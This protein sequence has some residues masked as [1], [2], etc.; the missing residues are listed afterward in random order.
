MNLTQFRLAG[1]EPKGI[2][3]YIHLHVF[4]T[5]GHQA[6]WKRLRINQDQCVEQMKQSHETALQAIS[7]SE[8]SSRPENASH[9]REQLVLQFSRFD[10]ME[11]GEADRTVE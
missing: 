1:A 7:P 10:V 8:N 11:H 9:F 2:R 3:I 5:C 6:L 4:K